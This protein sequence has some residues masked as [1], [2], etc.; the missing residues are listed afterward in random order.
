[1]NTKT[2]K[3]DLNKYKLY[4]KIKAKQGDTKSRFLLFQLLDGSI[5][6]NLKNRSVRAYMIKPDGREIF[7]DLIVNNYN[8]G[9]CT[10][11][12]TNQVLAAQGIVKIEL[13]VTEGDKKLTSSVFELEVVKSINSEKS[14]VSTNEF[15]ALL[16]GLAALS[17][18]DNYKNS[19][20]E[21]EINKANKAEVEEK[22]ISVE[23]KI[24]N[25]SEQLEQK[26][27]KD[28][29]NQ[30]KNQVN[31]FQTE[32]DLNPNKDTE[33][34][35]LRTNSFGDSF[36]ISNDRINTIEKASM[37]TRDILGTKENYFYS[38][39]NKVPLPNTEF[40]A[41]SYDV[42]GI[43]LIV[44][45]G[46]IQHYYDEYVLIDE[47]GSIFEHSLKDGTSEITKSV[48]VSNA[49]SL[50]VSTNQTYIDSIIVKE[51]KNN[52][53]DK[54]KEFNLK[55]SKQVLPPISIKNGYWNKVTNEFVSHTEYKFI[56]YDV[57]LINELKLKAKY[58]LYTNLYVLFDQHNDVIDRV[59]F[60]EIVSFE[61][62]VDV[63]KA[64]TI[65]VT[66]AN[67]D[68][69]SLEVTFEGVSV[70]SKLYN[71]EK[72]SYW[73]NKKIVWL[74]TSIPA[75]GLTGFFNDN[76]YP[77]RVGKILGATV[78]NEAIGS[79]CIHCKNP[80]LISSSN[81]YGFISNFE[82]VSRCLTNTIEEMNWI[83]NNYNSS[84]FTSGKPASAPNGATIRGYSW[85]NKINK[86]KNENIDLW[87]IDHGFNDFG[88]ADY[89]DESKYNEYGKN[90]LYTFQG[91]FDFIISKIKDMNPFARIVIIG[92]YENQNRPEIAE[93]QEKIAKRYS[94]PLF[95]QWEVY[96]WSQETIEPYGKWVADSENPSLYNWVTTTEKQSAIPYLYLWLPD[97]VHP[98][99][100]KSGNTLRFMA[101]H[102]AQWLDNNVR[103]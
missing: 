21:M 18:Y 44:I 92:N 13:M 11:E 2:I 35:A 46:T 33:L 32:Q 31:D 97:K 87:V 28:E 80:N 14:I 71:A 62:I 74:G 53:K 12:L 16:N 72:I 83:V 3:F 40:G 51:V 77:Q 29:V 99:T 100:D 84:I 6:F 8:L 94:L 91:A 88:Y 90:N 69:D 1:M 86:Y 68:I 5:P 30:L 56:T 96:G 59:G 27:S 20:K 15:T 37:L 45:N 24:K 60:N 10:L 61:N 25:N 66:V 38:N 26:A 9:Y 70:I 67:E 22:F 47:N 42:K 81:P 63:G 23:E 73:K 98:H 93:Y 49:S 57:S 43:D 65:G 58:S 48:D 95:K 103:S 54:L 64:T 82:K 76:A 36:P 7:N 85:E 41:K 17:E 39:G 75:G 79:S 52:L 4:E 19:V 50:I 89:L 34:V 78:Y 55:N 101:E 102:N